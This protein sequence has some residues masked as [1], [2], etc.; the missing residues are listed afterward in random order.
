MA[1][2]GPGVENVLMREF[3]HK[4]DHVRI[5][6]RRLVL[7]RAVG[8]ILSMVVPAVLLLVASDWFWRFSVG[9]RC[10]LLATFLI[11]TCLLYRKILLPAIGFRPSRVSIAHRIE[12]ANPTL[13]GR[14]VPVVGLG[15][16]GEAAPDTSDGATH[17]ISKTHV[18]T[19]M[20]PG[21]SSG[22]FILGLG[23]LF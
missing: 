17:L 14:C 5:R 1:S 21:A 4:L 22:W 11:T 16:T 18:R 6:A 3:A 13:R 15:D 23:M 10:L 2:D 9:T 8:L 19:A 7:A 12:R 20:K